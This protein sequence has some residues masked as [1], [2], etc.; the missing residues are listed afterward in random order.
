MYG[1]WDALLGVNVCDEGGVSP[2]RARGL[3][4]FDNNLKT[5]KD[6]GKIESTH[7]KQGTHTQQAYNL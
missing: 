7:N 2:E 5:R 3:S 1:C 6:T 4:K